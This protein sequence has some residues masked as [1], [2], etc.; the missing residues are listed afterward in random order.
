MRSFVDDPRDM[1]HPYTTISNG[2]GTPMETNS[3]DFLGL[4]GY[5]SAERIVIVFIIFSAR[6]CSSL[7]CNVSAQMFRKNANA[8]R[9]QIC[10][11]NLTARSFCVPRNEAP[12][13]HSKHESH[14]NRRSQYDCHLLPAS[15]R[16]GC[17]ISLK[18]G[19][20]SCRT[21]C[22]CT[23]CSSSS[24]RTCASDH[25]DGCDRRLLA[26]R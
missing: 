4:L 22:R 14:C 2:N 15:S 25:S 23:V 18:T 6:V 24:T 17:F 8:M 5:F 12:A 10:F 20:S 21:F 19:L 13:N 7:G 11:H 16:H 3:S 26:I 9:H 1:V